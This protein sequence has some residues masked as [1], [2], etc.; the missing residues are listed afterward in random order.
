LLFGCRSQ[1]QGKE[2]LPVHEALIFV[3][4]SRRTNE[5]RRGFLRVSAEIT[6]GKDA[7]KK[8]VLKFQEK[9]S[10]TAVQ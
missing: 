9:L 2:A 10:Q 4:T 8:A 3:P 1:L 7:G 6:A 5:L